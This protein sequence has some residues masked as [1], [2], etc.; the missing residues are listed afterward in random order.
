MTLALPLIGR[1]RL[2]RA[3]VLG[4]LTFCAVYLTCGTLHLR[5]PH[6]LEP[7]ALD[8]SI[9]FLPWTIWVYLSQFALLLAALLLARTDI[10]R[11]RAFYAMLLATLLAAI[12]FLAWPTQL[13]RV[14]LPQGGFTASAWRLLYLADVPGNCFPS[15]HVALAVLSATLLLRTG[16]IWRLAAPLWVLAIALSTLTT[17]QHIAL[18][19]AGGAVLAPTAWALAGRLFSYERTRAAFRPAS[20]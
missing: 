20:H 6:L 3:V 5:A 9:P 7:T 16:A 14:P 15:L 12:V 10:D 11:S 2:G 8:V 1:P 13:A 19:V 18:D 4:Y 17:R